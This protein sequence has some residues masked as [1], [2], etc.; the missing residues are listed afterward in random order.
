[1][2]VQIRPAQVT[3]LHWSFVTMRTLGLLILFAAFSVYITETRNLVTRSRPQRHLSLTVKTKN[4]KN[5]KLQQHGNP[6]YR[7]KTRKPSYVKQRKPDH[8]K[9]NRIS[10]HKTNK[11]HHKNNKNHVLKKP[12][13]DIDV[14]YITDIYGPKV[15]VPTIIS[16]SNP[17]L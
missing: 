5:I 6:V 8:G 12:V 9:K 16:E 10:A 1:M 4:N 11:A 2:G 13:H 14:P 17:V 15:E 7:K 3:Q